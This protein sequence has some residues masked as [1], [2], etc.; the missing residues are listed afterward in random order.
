MVRVQYDAIVVLGRGLNV[1]S[2][3]LDEQLGETNRARLMTALKS[4]H[5][6]KWD[7][8]IP[9]MVMSGKGMAA[10]TRPEM[11]EA[12]KMQA[13]AVREGIDPS[14]I[15]TEDNSLDTWGNAIHTREIL[16]ELGVTAVQVITSGWHSPRAMAIFDHVFGD[17]ILVHGLGSPETPT[18]HD[19][20]GEK[21]GSASM[22]HVIAN[23]RRGD[24]AS[25]LHHLSETMDIYSGLEF[26]QAA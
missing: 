11:V 6:N 25:I 18:A 1:H 21:S 7:S 2:D 12:K 10:L 22:T 26:A 20:A 4:W 13:F 8:D 17:S 5:R 15:K 14:V 16:E 9:Y 19:L 24:V 23:S 3:D